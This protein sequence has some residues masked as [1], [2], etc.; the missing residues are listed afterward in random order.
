MAW[1]TRAVYEVPA[2]KLAPGTYAW[3]VWPALRRG[4]KTPAFADLIGRA[5]FV[6]KA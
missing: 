6:V 4:A 1:P 5:T 3:F 2:G